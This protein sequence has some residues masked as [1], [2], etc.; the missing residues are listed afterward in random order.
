[1]TG[2]TTSS[3]IK[4]DVEVAAMGQGKNPTTDAT[5][6]MFSPGIFG[7]NF[8]VGAVGAA[9]PEPSTWAMMLLGFAGIGF[10]GYRKAKTRRT[11][12]SAA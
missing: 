6:G 9:I 4:Y 11:E 3:A 10:V 7:P 8:D 1:M 5:G 2:L 12:P